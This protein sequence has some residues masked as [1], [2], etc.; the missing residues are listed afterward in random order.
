MIDFFGDKK[1][2]HVE[3]AHQRLSQHLQEIKLLQM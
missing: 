2:M 3:F 1:M